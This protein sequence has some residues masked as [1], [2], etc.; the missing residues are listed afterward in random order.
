MKVSSTNG[1]RGAQRSFTIHAVGVRERGCSQFSNLVRFMFNLPANLSNRLLSWVAVRKPMNLDGHLWCSSSSSN[2]AVERHV[3]HACLALTK[4]Q[5]TADWFT[6]RRFRV[7]GTI[8]GLILLSSNHIRSM[9]D[10][11]ERSVEAATHSDLFD[12]MMS[13]WFST[14]RSTEAMMRGTVN[15]KPVVAAIKS[16]PWCMELFE[17]GMLACREFPWLACSPD[18]LARIQTQDFEEVTATVEIKTSVSDD[19]T[20]RALAVSAASI[21]YCHVGDAIFHRHVPIDHVGQLLHQLVVL[22][23]RH[24]V[25]VAATETGISY[26]LIARV[27][28]SIVNSCRL[29]LHST[30]DQIVKW[31]H[32]TPLVPPTFLSSASKKTIEKELKFW[33]ALNTKVIQQGPMEPVKLFRHGTQ[34]MYSKLKGGVDGAT[35]FRAILRS[36]STSVGW[37]QKIVM[38]TFKNLF[39]NSFV[40][41]RMSMTKDKLESEETFKNLDVYRSMLNKV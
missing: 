27:S 9:I 2:S 18:A 17:V 10:L 12:K 22:D 29:I 19:S 14:S 28:D 40:A 36:S 25:Y 37:E 32:V 41:W 8:A 24:L 11:P 16:L 5:R 21:V 38:Q 33:T 26:I 23:V 6:L 1:R 15:E 31:I 20:L 7:T 34:M 4:A 13:S 35:Q 30:C 3:A 39:V